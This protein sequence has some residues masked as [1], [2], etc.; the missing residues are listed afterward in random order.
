MAR[1]ILF[2]D[3][4]ADRTPCEIARC[5]AIDWASACAQLAA[6]A[7]GA[8][9]IARGP[10]HPPTKARPFYVQSAAS[11]ALDAPARRLRA[12]PLPDF[13]RRLTSRS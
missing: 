9:R 4:G 7:N 8:H 12:T 5:E 3:L 10:T 13:S 1:W 6:H 11:H 2:R